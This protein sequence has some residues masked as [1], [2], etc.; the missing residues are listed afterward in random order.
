MSRALDKFQASH[1][2]VATTSTGTAQTGDFWAILTL[3]DTTFSTL[4]G[5]YTGTLTGTTIPAGLT[6]YGEFT[7]YT[8]GT[9]R[10]IAYRAVPA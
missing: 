1:G 5:N 10:I 8:V 9:G 3:A 4:T 6:I 2:F 7:G